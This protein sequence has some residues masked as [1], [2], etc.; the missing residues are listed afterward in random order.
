MRYHTSRFARNFVKYIFLHMALLFIACANLFAVNNVNEDDNHIYEPVVFGVWWW[1]IAPQ[2]YTAHLD[3]L[4]SKG[5]N[6]IYYHVY[7]YNFNNPRLG[8]FIEDAGNRGMRVFF[9]LNNENYIWDHQ[10][11]KS[12]MDKFFAYQENAPQN[13]RFSGLHM[14]IEP[15]LHPLY[16]YNIYEFSQDFM[17]FIVWVNENFRHRLLATY[18]GAT[19]DWDIPCWFTMPVKYRGETWTLYQ[20]IITE[21]DRVFLMAYQ[22]SAAKTYALAQN[23]I[24]FARSIN[25]LIVVGVETSAE[26]ALS[27]ETYYGLGKLYFYEQ[28]KELK[29][30]LSRNTNNFG[31]AIHHMSSW[32]NMAP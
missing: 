8:P 15:H 2:Q 16:V 19:I 5:V 31:I 9:L 32:F 3:F 27:E 24:T 25:R 6:E 14:D 29:R 12:V 23:E 13:R 18:K 20:A 22:N 11:F 4:E 1:W 26:Y 10:G 7:Q 21:A 28:L 30:L 17:D